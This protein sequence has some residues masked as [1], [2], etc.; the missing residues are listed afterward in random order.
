MKS[1][2]S[3]S[4][5]SQ[6]RASATVS[7]LSV[8]GRVMTTIQEQTVPL[9][10]CLV[11]GWCCDAIIALAVTGLS[12]EHNSPGLINGV[13]LICAI[14]VALAYL[15]NRGAMTALAARQTASCVR[16]AWKSALKH[17]RPLALWSLIH[18]AVF[19]IA[20]ALLLFC[21]RLW[22][23]AFVTGTVKQFVVSAAPFPVP[24]LGSLMQTLNEGFAVITGEAMR[25]QVQHHVEVF[26]L[27]VA[28][29]VPSAMPDRNMTPFI[30]GF[31]ILAVLLYLPLSFRSAIVLNRQFVWRSW[32]ARALVSGA[33]M[34]MA[35]AIGVDVVDGCLAYL[36][37]GL[38]VS[39][40]DSMFMPAL[41]QG[42]SLT[43]VA[44]IMSTVSPVACAL[45]YGTIDMAAALMQAHLHMAV[46]DE[47]YAR[48]PQ[49]AP[50]P[51]LLTTRGQQQNGAE[52]QR[53]RGVALGVPL[54]SHLMR[55]RVQ[56]R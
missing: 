33:C 19:C 2:Y 8:L 50:A 30:I 4:V 35:I 10:G 22:I 44:A 39:Y 26:S 28:N 38:P 14:I 18:A 20:T 29:T 11:I 48:V 24:V 5:H 46:S 12:P 23:P 17:W 49:P 6:V 52:A 3:N 51:S 42:F 55:L 45:A 32:S 36:F 41:M 16:Q 9:V 15:L 47:V 27:S 7:V 25:L 34:V 56:H 43:G 53:R 54:L 37:I 21:L 13:W 31:V 1:R 40:A